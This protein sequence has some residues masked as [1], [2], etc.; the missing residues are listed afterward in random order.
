[1]AAPG[2]PP[3]NWCEWIRCELGQTRKCPVVRPLDGRTKP[4]RDASRLS[5]IACW[6]ARGQPPGYRKQAN[7]ETFTEAPLIDSQT[8]T[9]N[10]KN[11]KDPP[12]PST[13]QAEKQGNCLRGVPVR[14]HQGHGGT[15]QQ[16]RTVPSTHFEKWKS[17]L[18]LHDQKWK[19]GLIRL[20]RALGFIARG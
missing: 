14:C 13:S 3:F 18:G 12:T 15:L 11:P 1:M 10:P 9:L 2:P 17:G 19:S 5:S 7:I 4:R 20:T 8:A 16:G 6:C